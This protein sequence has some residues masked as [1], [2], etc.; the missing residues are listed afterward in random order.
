MPNGEKGSAD[1]YRES[2][3]VLE[4]AGVPFLVGGAYAFAFYT[5]I[6]RDTKDFD[7]FLRPRDVDRALD[8]FQRAGYGAEKTYPH[9]L[10]K[11]RAGTDLIDLIFRAGN[12]LCGVDDLWFARA[13]RAELLRSAVQLCPPEE[14]VWMKA[15]IMERE[16]YDGADVAHLF[17][18]CAER[19]DWRHLLD[20]FGPDWEVLLSH[21][22]LFGYIYPNERGR[23]PK[24]VMEELVQRF[25]NEAKPLAERICRGTLLS[26]AQ[27]L[28]DVK[29]R[30]FRDARLE[31]RVQM[32]P[33]EIS[34]WTKAID[35]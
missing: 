10:A 8:A 30:G 15:F 31:S 19:I 5:G 34:D 6:S 3:C 18:S 2:M 16:R 4:R 25:P 32:G 12:G 33:A 29:E 28:I 27:Y 13:E 24:H 23:I 11:V 22:V 21:L 14:I 35:E 7:L 17:Q 20:R 26:R 9:W 1:F